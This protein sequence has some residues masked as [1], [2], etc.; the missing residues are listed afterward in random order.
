MSKHHLHQREVLL[1]VHGQSC[2]LAGCCVM[3]AYAMQPT[4]SNVGRSASPASELMQLMLCCSDTAGVADPYALPVASKPCCAAHV[5]LPRLRS[6][7]ASQQRLSRCPRP[8]P[9]RL[10]VQPPQQQPWPPL[11]PDPPLRPLM[12]AP[13]RPLGKGCQMEVCLAASA[14]H[15]K[16]GYAEMS[17]LLRTASVGHL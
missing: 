11:P 6:L 2:C 12:L 3:M 9:P 14:S 5:Q 16:L 15:N 8:L 17:L 1:L 10:R 4:F 7:P 13:L